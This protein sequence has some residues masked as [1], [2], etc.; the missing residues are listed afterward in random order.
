MLIHSTA[1]HLFQLITRDEIYR[2]MMLLLLLLNSQQQQQQRV[3][4]R[5]WENFPL[6]I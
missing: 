6:F 2:F 3:N 1:L 5:D 4:E